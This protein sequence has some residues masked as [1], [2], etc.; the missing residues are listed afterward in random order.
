MRRIV[1]L[2]SVVALMVVMLA[3]SVAPAF[4]APKGFVCTFPDGS[5]VKYSYG[6]FKHDASTGGAFPFPDAI[7]RPQ[8]VL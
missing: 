8:G 5:Q 3:M 6:Q 4:A 2:L 1:V 7:C